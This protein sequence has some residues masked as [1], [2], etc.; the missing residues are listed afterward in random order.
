MQIFFK[1]FLTLLIFNNL[2]QANLKTKF[3]TNIKKFTISNVTNKI[4]TLQKTTLKIGQSGVIIHKYNDTHSLIIANATVIK[5]KNDK[6]TLLIFNNK[7]L[8]Q[9]AIPTSKLIPQNGD[10]F[11]ANHLYTSSLLITPNY[12]SSQ[13][14]HNL[15]PKQNFLNPDI[16]ASYLKIIS[17]PIPSQKDIQA[18]CKKND[19][20]TIFIV[21]NNKFYILDTYSFKKLHM[22]NINITDSST[23]KPFFTKVTNIETEF[24]DFGDE[25][26]KDYNKFYSK[27]LEI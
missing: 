18:F 19:I 25:E 5:N 21:I 27:L 14:I 4:A 10:I 26:I 24:F 20:G 13:N 16:L 6:T 9:D 7:M 8:K 17:T 12:E 1:I 2:I 11:I 23:Q 22:S 3:D 15:Y